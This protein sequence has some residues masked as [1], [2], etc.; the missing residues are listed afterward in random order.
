M[1]RLLDRM[2]QFMGQ[3]LPLC[4]RLMPV[5][6]RPEHHVVAG[7]KGERINS[8]SS[9]RRLRVGVYTDLTEIVPEPWLEVGTRSGVQGLPGR[10]Q[11]L[12]H[13]AGRFAHSGA[14]AGGR[15]L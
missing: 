15:P 1:M 9:F 14:R 13:D 4:V 7:R 5:Q 3:K 2:G 6:S 10:A 11:Y 8:T 12:V